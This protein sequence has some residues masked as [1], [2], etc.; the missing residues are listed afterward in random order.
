MVLTVGRGGTPDQSDDQSDHWRTMVKR[1]KCE[2]TELGERYTLI[3]GRWHFSAA[4]FEYV[5]WRFAV[6]ICEASLYWRTWSFHAYPV[7]SP[8]RILRARS[9]S[10]NLTNAGF[11]RAPA[12]IA[13]TMRAHSLPDFPVR[14]CSVTA[15]TSPLRFSP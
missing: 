3:L 5:S 4:R 13:R 12:R 10:K 2:V 15:A 9:F 1:W 8:S 7:F 11:E 14:I 6:S